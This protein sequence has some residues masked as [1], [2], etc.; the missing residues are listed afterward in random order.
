MTTPDQPSPGALADPVPDARPLPDPI[1]ADGVAPRIRVLRV[2]ARLNVGGPAQHAMVLGYGLRA[3]G[4]DSLLVHGAVG[5]DEATLE[6]LLPG[7]RIRAVKIPE[8]GRRIR[9]WSDLRALYELTRLVFRE[10]PDV[11]HTHTAKAGT[12]GRLAALAYNVVRRRRHRCAVVHTFHGHVFHGYFGALGSALVRAIE[13]VMALLTDRIVTISESQKRDI[14]DVYRVAPPWKT[15]V[16][17]LGL[18]LDPLLR[19]EENLAL[20]DE[21]GFGPDDV[22]FGYV[23]RFVPIKDLPTL[24]GAFAQLAAEVPRA[25]LLLV[26][27]GEQRRALEVLVAELGLDDRVR[28][29]GWRRDLAAVY[30]AMDVGVLSSLNEGTPVALIEAMAAG[31][32][33]I[34]TAVGGVRDVV[35]DGWTGLVVPPSSARALADAMLR[36]ASDRESRHRLGAAA[37]REIA[38][39]FFPGRLVS[40]IT[41]L[42]H[43]AL[44]ERRALAPGAVGPRPMARPIRALSVIARL[45]IG[46]PARHATLLGAGLRDRGFEPLLVH[47]SIGDTE[48][49]LEDLVLTPRLRA[50]KIPELGRRI[51][52]WSDLRALYQ[53]TRLI[54]RER[55]DVVHTHTAKAGALGRLAAFLFNV[56]HARAHRCV[57]IHTFHGHVFSRYFGAAGSIAVRVVER[58]LATITDRIITLSEAQRFDICQLYRVA[59]PS[60]TVVVKLGMDLASLLTVPAD[61]RPGGGLGFGP[62]ELVFGYVG[63]FV[64]IKNLAMLV[65]AFARVAVAVPEA[66]LMLVGDGELR[67]MLEELVDALGLGPRVRFTGWQRDLMAVYGSMDVCVLSSWNEGTPVAL[68]EAMAAGR[69]VIATAVGGVEDVV[70]DGRTGLVVPAGEPAALAEAMIRLAR[71]PDERHWLGLA[72]RQAA[73]QSFRPERLAAEISGCYLDALVAKRGL[74]EARP[75]PA[76]R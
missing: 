17:E 53:L 11:V 19:L 26:G 64:P 2:I 7:R 32:P 67:G 15:E 63:R 8:L 40:E 30:G 39:R 10:R 72:A 54:F 69:P 34:A 42:Y 58:G 5:S 46:G 75:V 59:A 61:V 13:R 74:A 35:S 4:F 52:P 16:V 62:R 23:G 43:R 29:A 45:N 12:L 48:G 49:S 71:N 36:L 65:H 66:R 44:V 73:A 76:A 27:D 56:T 31:R 68:I 70:T 1:S 18:E 60:K 41:H 6:D 21:L 3:Q 57:V 55:P 9:P 51:R 37:R 28:F 24:I 33:V 22:V 20:R 38:S 14:C 47:G 25:R 50:L